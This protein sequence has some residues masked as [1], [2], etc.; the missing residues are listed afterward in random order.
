ML[1]V[2]I[3]K[4][5]YRFDEDRTILSS[6][7]EVNIEIPTA[8]FDDR[9]KPYGGCRLCVVSV[10]GNERPV[11][12]CNTMLVDGME[13]ETHSKSIEDLRRTL[14][15]MLA[16]TYPAAAVGAFPEK[17]FHKYLKQYG[18]I[19]GLKSKARPSLQD[20]SHPYIHVDM[21][22]CIYCF[23]C[24]R[25]C[26]EVQGQYVWQVWNRGDRSIIRPD[27]KTNLLQSTCIS[28]GACVD[29]CPTGA[30]ED[31][32]RLE[33]MVPKTFI[34]TTCAY[35]GVGC[36]IE[37]GVR[38]DEIVQIR[39]SLRG[40]SNKGHLCSKGKYAFGY[41]H[42]TD[43]ITEP[44]IR[45]NG[46][47]QKVSFDEALNFVAESFSK[48][49]NAYGPN[50][51]GVLGSS[52][53]TNEENYLTQKFARVV[54]ET[55][56]VDNCARV[57][58]TPSA[59]ALKKMLGAGASTNSLDDIEKASVI[60]LCGTNT[61]ENHPVTGARVKQAALAGAKLIVIDPRK[62]ELA[63]YADYHLQLRAGTDIPLLN[64][65][66][67]TIVTERLFDQAFIQ[68]RVGEWEPFQKFIESW[69]PEKASEIC[70]VDA[71]MIRKAA[72][73]YASHGPSMV[74]NGL[75]VTEHVQGTETVM[76][77]VNLALM[78]GNLGKAGSGVNPMRGQNN[79]QGAGHMGCVPTGLAGGISIKDGKELC[80]RIWKAKIPTSRGMNLFQMMDESFAGSLRALWV[81]GYDV[82]LSNP[83]GH[84]TRKSFQ[85]LDCVVIQDLFMT[86]TAQEFGHVF[87]PV[88]S[89]F[90]KEG[91]F[92]NGERRVQLIRKAIEPV[93]ESKSDWEI[94]CALAK[95]MGKGE[96]FSFGSPRDIWDEVRSVWPGANGITYDRI[97]SGGLQWPCPDENH[98]GTEVLHTDVFPIGQKAAL[99]TI[100]YVPTSEQV[101]EEY[102][103]LLTTGRELYQFNAST[104]SG[105]TKN[106]ELRPT[107][108]L[109][110]SA[111]DASCLD[112][113]N[114]ELAKIRSRYGEAIL[115]VR[116][117]KTVK[118]GEAFAT[119]NSVSIFLNQVTSAERDRLVDTPEY[120]VTAIQ[121]E[122][123]KS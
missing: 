79:V 102:P 104:M 25:I 60:V 72:R 111:A 70:K 90:E 49:K 63:E 34:K 15:E 21:S 8:C 120:K 16:D 67:H 20:R 117:S 52:R 88:C 93:G 37:T 71:E 29:T 30:L 96:F 119:F 77:I 115:P 43:R 113:E 22:Q 59:A 27:S 19:Q 83:N 14:L 106:Q 84:Q 100:D 89:S 26:E 55:N 4:K 36:E 56:N 44:M 53:A 57:C 78:T 42:A 114:G 116:I 24:V 64:A 47:W 50:A 80:E 98:P 103:F 13:I 1:Q 5:N 68:D 12:A 46:S 110:L 97:E 17:E 45:K 76:C 41:V 105:R 86:K 51:I 54:L 108:T 11:T 66:A 7:R 99:R 81:I 94:I 10:K 18:L 75:G 92:M 9:L 109:D 74:L 82:L 87:F 28:C 85:N 107:D 123:F 6:L 69:T 61:T 23:R 31:K 112:L 101:S 122:R 33:K 95:K 39:P 118:D 38:D 91:T 65:M 35:C 40:A 121:I 32:T 2:V 62:I 73:L 58:H 3:N 48:T